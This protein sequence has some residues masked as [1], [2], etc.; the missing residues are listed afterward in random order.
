[1]SDHTITLSQYAREIKALAKNAKKE[2]K[3]RGQSKN[4][5][6]DRAL[7]RLHEDVDGHEWIIYTWAYPY[8]LIHSENED[9][10]FEQMGRDALEGLDNYAAVMQRMAFAAMLADAEQELETLFG[11]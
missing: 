11:G 4:E 6:R 1:M 3:E 7:E 5:H 8:V 10:L 9:A 2:T